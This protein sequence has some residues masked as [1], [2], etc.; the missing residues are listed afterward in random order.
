MRFSRL[1]I[2]RCTLLQVGQVV[3][4]DPYGRDKYED[5][6][7]SDV[8]CRVDQIR[9]VVTKDDFGNDVVMENILFLS[10]DQELDETM[11]IVNVKDKNGSDV[12]KGTF[13][14]KKINPV[15]RRSRLHHY[16]ITL[17]KESD[18]SGE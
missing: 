12:L 4:K 16:E 5:V 14:I 17:E 13:A 11:K 3:G 15:Y 18:T 7:I 8:P 1:L 2:H 6:P 9:R 10:P